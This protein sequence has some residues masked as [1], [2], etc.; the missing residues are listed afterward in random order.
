MPATID[1][2]VQAA[3]TTPLS[4]VIIGVGPADFSSMNA[5]DGDGKVLRDSRG[6]TSTRDMY[7][8]LTSVDR[9]TKRSTDR[10][11]LSLLQCPVCSV[12]PLRW[13]P[14][15]AH[16]R[17]ARGDPE[18]ALPVHAR[19]WDRAEPSDPACVQVVCRARQHWSG[20]CGASCCCCAWCLSSTATTW[21]TYCSPSTGA[22]S[23]SS[24]CCT[25]AASARSAPVDPRTG[26]ASA[27][28]ERASS[29]ASATGVP[30]TGTTAAAW[31]PA[32]GLRSTAATR[33][34]DAR[35]WSA[36]GLPASGTVW[37]PRLPTARRLPWTAS[38]LCSATSRR[39]GLPA[40]GLPG[41]AAT[42]SARRTPPSGARVPWLPRL[43]VSQLRTDN[44]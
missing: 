4:I 2:L 34:P 30:A 1:A 12:Q 32:P 29:A 15:S 26:A 38:G 28:P 25:A 35:L 44:C 23:S 27:R 31:V 11:T 39:P 21:R 20:R 43:V 5:L 13:E 19:T 33:V 8:R 16:A 42:A 22:W 6:R 9:V 18:P 41:A 40:T 36:A 37:L 7:V 10:P 3:N 24:W 14:S 17:D